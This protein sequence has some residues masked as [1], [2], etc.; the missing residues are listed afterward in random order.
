VVLG[1]HTGKS[2]STTVLTFRSR[3]GDGAS[4]AVVAVTP[5]LAVSFVGEGCDACFD[6]VD[7]DDDCFDDGTGDVGLDGDLGEAE[8]VMAVPDPL[9]SDPD[10]ALAS[11]SLFP[12]PDRPL[13]SP[14]PPLLLALDLWSRE[15]EGEKG[16]FSV[17]SLS[18]SLS[19]MRSPPPHSTLSFTDII[20]SPPSPVPCS[21]ASASRAR[22]R[23]FCLKS[24][25]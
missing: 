11:P 3:L 22:C 14:P 23:Q 1:S 9:V 24:S 5:T 17:D 21:K 18:S 12:D 25:M 13:E 10:R 2:S 6:D 4:T 8:G 16:S 19:K 20:L 15:N 7:D